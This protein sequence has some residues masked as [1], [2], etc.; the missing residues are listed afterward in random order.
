MWN[1]LVKLISKILVYQTNGFCLNRFLM[2][3]YLT[4][5][6]QMLPLYVK[7][8]ALQAQSSPPQFTSFVRVN[9]PSKQRIFNWRYTFNY[10]NVKWFQIRVHIFQWNHIS[11]EFKLECCFCFYLSQLTTELLFTQSQIQCQDDAKIADLLWIRL[12]WAVQS[13]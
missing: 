3:Y 11:L 12:F 9:T 10:V 6:Y 1:N 4:F 7:W 8:R 2:N 13:Q 5:Y